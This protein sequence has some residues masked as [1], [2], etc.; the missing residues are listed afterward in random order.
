MVTSTG[1][2]RPLLSEGFCLSSHLL[3]TR[4]LLTLCPQVLSFPYSHSNLLPHP[5]V[6]FL[7]SALSNLWRGP[8][9]GVTNVMRQPR[10][11]AWS[12]AVELYCCGTG[13]CLLL[14]WKKTY[15]HVCD[16]NKKRSVTRRWLLS[17]CSRQA[18]LM[19]LETPPKKLLLPKY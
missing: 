18:V 8:S 13:S 5:W 11:T 9:C 14:L 10:V 2:F 4:P 17:S 15:S 19:W 3:D 1:S 12:C 7:K 16:W 6:T